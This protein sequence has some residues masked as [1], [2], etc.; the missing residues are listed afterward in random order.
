MPSSLKECVLVLNPYMQP[1]LLQERDNR[2]LQRGPVIPLHSIALLIEG[3]VTVGPSSHSQ[4]APFLVSLSLHIFATENHHNG[5]AVSGHRPV[6][7]SYSRC[8][9]PVQKLVSYGMY[10][11]PFYN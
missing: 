6:S 2:I 8:K 7:E 4:T 9:I 3:P 1:R 10:Q 5:M 11:N